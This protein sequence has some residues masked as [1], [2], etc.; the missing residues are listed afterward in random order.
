[1]SQQ[2]KHKAK[3]RKMVNGMLQDGSSKSHTHTHM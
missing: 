2:M 3:K 1:M